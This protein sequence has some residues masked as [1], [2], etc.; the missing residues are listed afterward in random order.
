MESKK[1]E[2]RKKGIWFLKLVWMLI[3]LIIILILFI[4]LFNDIE[5]KR[6]RK[7]GLSAC[8]IPKWTQLELGQARS[9]EHLLVSYVG[10]WSQDLDHL[11]LAS[12]CISKSWIG[13]RVAGTQTETG[14]GVPMRCLHRRLQ[15][16]SLRHLGRICIYTSYSEIL[17]TSVMVLWGV[18][19]RDRGLLN[20]IH[21]LSKR[22]QGAALPF[23]QLETPKG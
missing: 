18:A 4:S 16:N 13:S 11:P 2:G 22:P 14:T 5:K 17:I 21:V 12:W 19:L 10:A 8:S 20:R 1:Q 23:P 6:E 7:R 3:S 15:F 9:Q